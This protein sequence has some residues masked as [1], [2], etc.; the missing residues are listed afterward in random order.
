MSEEPVT[1]PTPVTQ[2]SSPLRPYQ[3]NL[4]GPLLKEQ[5]ATIREMLDNRD[6]LDSYV[7]TLA[8]IESLLNELAD[9]AWDN[10]GI[11]GL[12]SGPVGTMLSYIQRK[13]LPLEV[14]DDVLAEVVNIPVPPPIEHQLNT[15]LGLLGLAELRRRIDVA[16]A[17]RATNPPA[18]E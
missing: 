17:A 14:V 18:A 7:P 9:Q 11:D 15:L 2:E 1:Q 4:D 12:L 6:T 8:G 3:L 16:A 10:H 5:R 13:R